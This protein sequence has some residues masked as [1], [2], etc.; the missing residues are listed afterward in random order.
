MGVPSIRTVQADAVHSAPDR[1]LDKNYEHWNEYFPVYPI[2][3]FFTNQKL[4]GLPRNNHPTLG[5]DP[6]TL[7]VLSSIV[8]IS[9]ESISGYL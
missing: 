2:E 3:G 8:T 6:L 7:G 4:F 9:C 1:K 5:T